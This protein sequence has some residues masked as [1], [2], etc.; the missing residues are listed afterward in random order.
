MA[1]V[2]SASPQYRFI[3]LIGRK[4]DGALFFFI[5]S[6]PAGSRDYSPPGQIYDEAPESYR[7]VFV[8]QNATTEGPY[9]DRWGTWVL[10]LTPIH[11]PRTAISNLA[12]PDDALAMVRNAVDSY[13]KNGREH[14][15]KELNNPQGELCKGDLYAFAYDQN[16]T[17]LAHSVNPELV[18]QN[19]LDKKD[20]SMGKYFHR[21]IQQ[22]AQSKG[23]GWVNYEYE[24]PVSKQQDAKTTYI[25]RTDD[26]VICAGAYKGTGS[27]L[28]VLGMYIDAS[29]WNWM[30]ARAA[31]PP[32]LLTLTL[33]AILLAGS[34]LLARR[35]RITGPLPSRM[36]HLE[37]ALTAAVGLVL[38][39]FAAWML[40]EYETRNRS[41]AFAL[42]AAGRTEVFA[43]IL[44]DL[45]DIKLEGLSR[46][47]E[48]SDQVTPEE[49]RQFTG[50]LTKNQTVQAWEW[51]PAVPEADKLRFEEAARAAG[52]TGFDIWQ[53]DAQG[54]RVSAYGRTE[55]YPVFRI[56]PL[57][58]NE[59]ALGYDLGSE[60]LRSA[61]L[62]EA[63]R[64]GLTTG[65][66]PITL[67][68]ATGSQKG[69]LIY[70]PVFGR[71]EPRLLRGFALAVLQMGTLMRSTAQNNSVLMQISL[72]R[73]DIAPELL[74]ISWNPGSPP[75][76][77]LSGTRAVFAFGKVFGVTAH[78]RPEFINL[79]PVRLGWLGAL[80]GLV[81][82]AAITFAISG[83]RHRREELE[84][85]VAER[86]TE[87][88]ESEQSYRNQFA[89]NSSVML[90]I[91]P[92]DGAII[93]ANVAALSFYG[94]TREQLLT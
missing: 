7:R 12:S 50:V 43:E 37:P 62:E 28:A 8:T 67:V 66:D 79:Y 87:L 29:D 76:A 34:A 64:T 52:L 81:L 5:D 57:A 75:T 84:R 6:E 88:R 63:E 85:L 55:Y 11:D 45:R 90:L 53:K 41:K 33:A 71:G 94:Y 82:T 80:T 40:H 65:T 15:L 46:F 2:R 20:W 35:S 14:F 30:L 73:K 54:E 4:T 31:L 47:Y 39:L 16:M 10:A 32:A 56:A 83:I 17:M 1:A 23:S 78:A 58:G 21:E 51:I 13:R 93:D 89:G 70:R 91:D 72:L 19:L 92:T 36:R 22:V 60:P 69:M 86:T 42:L 24:N 48:I 3:Y 77:M 27:V 26:L 59:H 9:T 49:F 44:R 74:A 18:G 61:A 68:Q 38:T 25:E